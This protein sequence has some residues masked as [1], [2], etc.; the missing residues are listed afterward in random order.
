MSKGTRRFGCT[1]LSVW[2]RFTGNIPQ[3]ELRRIWI[4]SSK[5]TSIF[6]YC[7]LP[8]LLSE[9]SDAWIRSKAPGRERGHVSQPN[10]RCECFTLQGSHWQWLTVSHNGLSWALPWRPTDQLEREHNVQPLKHPGDGLVWSQESVIILEN[11]RSW[12]DMLTSFSWWEARKV[13]LHSCQPKE[14]S[15]PFVHLNSFHGADVDHARYGQRWCVTKYRRELH[16]TLFLRVR[17]KCGELGN[18]FSNFGLQ[19]GCWPSENWTVGP[20]LRR[21]I[22][23]TRR[24]LGLII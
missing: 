14:H 12:I 19:G 11:K 13:G 5:T 4:Y 9:Q 10:G 1:R 16:P 23:R 17:N 24:H 20:Y 2:L 8:P 7:L 15:A 18:G 6:H 21:K 3:F 22:W